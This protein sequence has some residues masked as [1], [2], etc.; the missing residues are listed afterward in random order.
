MKSSLFFK[1]L[2][3][4]ALIMLGGHAFAA[5][6]SFQDPG[7]S[8]WGGW[9]R[10]DAGTVYVHWEEYGDT[11]GMTNDFTPDA[12]FSGA[13]LGHHLT[14]NPGGFITGGGLGGNI[15]SFSDTPDFTTY[16]Q[17]AGP[18]TPGVGGAVTVALQIAN[19]GTDLDLSSVELMVGGVGVA[20]DS[21]T[22]L[23]SGSAG[24]PFG[25]AVFERL[26]LWT[27][28][29]DIGFYQFDYNALGSSL[30]LDA[31]SIDIGPAAVPIPAAVWLFASALLG[32]VS[33][34]RRPALVA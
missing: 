9:N 17:P 21:V 18:I 26:F 28:A 13:A 14:N 32:L 1:G 24:G 29:S 15:Y 23:F 20:A 30:S 31:L 6:T 4:C 3:L 33:I 27:L 10:G 22:T 7:T 11:D 8:S 5:S 19:L 16:T 34:R 2:S 12:G 25:G